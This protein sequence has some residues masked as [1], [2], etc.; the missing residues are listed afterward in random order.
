MELAM[1]MVDQRDAADAPC[2]LTVENDPME[3]RSK[4]ATKTMIG[5]LY[6]EDAMALRKDAV[7]EADLLGWEGAG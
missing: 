3:R 2:Q 1:S 7:H 5:L 6:R 4:A